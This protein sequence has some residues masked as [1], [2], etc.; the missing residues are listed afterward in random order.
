MHIYST[1]IASLSSPDKP[2]YYGVEG[3][4]HEHVFISFAWILALFWSG[5]SRGI[6]PLRSRATSC[7]FLQLTFLDEVMKLTFEMVSVFCM[8]ALDPMK[9]KPSSWFKPHGIWFG[10]WQKRNIMCMETFSPYLFTTSIQR[11]EVLCIP[12]TPLEGC[13]V[14]DVQGTMAYELLLQRLRIFKCPFLGIPSLLFWISLLTFYVTFGPY[15]HFLHENRKS[16]GERF[17]KIYG[18]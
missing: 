15:Q 2:A 12:P 4:R 7:V 14:P 18:P 11:C 10:G 17:I 13:L 3:M 9:F 8:V 16:L 6:P 5:A 1:V